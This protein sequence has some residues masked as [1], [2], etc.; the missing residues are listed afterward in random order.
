MCLG[1]GGALIFFLVIIWYVTQVIYTPKP[2]LD[3]TFRRRTKGC[4][5][6]STKK[7]RASER[8]VEKKDDIALNKANST[9]READPASD[10]TTGFPIQEI[11]SPEG[12]YSSHKSPGT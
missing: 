8:A 5:S 10:S 12:S 1:V 7:T 11:S 9:S 3:R 2:N 4:L 6:R